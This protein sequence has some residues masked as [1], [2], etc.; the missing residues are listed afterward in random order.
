MSKAAKKR[1]VAA[2]LDR[3]PVKETITGDDDVWLRELITSHPDYPHKFGDVVR[4]FVAPDAFGGRCFW[5]ER[6]DGVVDNFGTGACI[7]GHP[8]LRRRLVTACRAASQPDVHAF[9]A[10]YFN[11]SRHAT[12]QATGETIHW[13]DAHVDHVVPFNELATYWLDTRPDMSLEDIAPD[14]PGAT[15][16]TFKDPAVA[17]AFR[18]FHAAEAVMRIVKAIVNLSRGKR[19]EV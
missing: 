11:G 3:W 14:A 8:P 19:R 12:C 7:D 2:M 10:A 18:A 6:A 16:D 17:D 15:G 1:A 4:F 13:D 5:F 9:K